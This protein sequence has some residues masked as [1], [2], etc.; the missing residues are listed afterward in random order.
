[1]I[2]AFVVVLALTGVAYADDDPNYLAPH[3]DEPWWVSGQANGILQVQPGFH[4]PY[5]GANSFL[6]DDK[7]AASFVVTAY[8]G[9]EVTRN[10]ALVVAGESA[11][12]TGLSSALGIAGFTNLDVVRNPTLGAAPSAPRSALPPMARRPGPCRLGDRR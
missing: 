11:G 6:P 4:S 8:A 2:R 1:M 7:H 5:I 10:T 3:P 12:G 9:Y